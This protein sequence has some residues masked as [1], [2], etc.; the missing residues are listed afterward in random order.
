MNERSGSEDPTVGVSSSDSVPHE[1]HAPEAQPPLPGEPIGV[2]LAAHRKLRGIS[3][4]ELCEQTRI[5]LRSLERL[6]GGAF[7]GQADGFVRG[8]VRTV[9]ISLG[10]DPEE[11]V[12]RMQSEPDG[13]MGRRPMA[14]LSL[15]R[16]FLTAVLVFGSAGLIALG[17]SVLDRVPDG[18]RGSAEP[19]SIRRDPVR[20]LA[21]A[22]GI[23]GLSE[24][25]TT[26]AAAH[27]RPE[28]PV[29]D[30][31]TALSHQAVPARPRSHVR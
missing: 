3:L 26:L 22:Q 24:R 30:D 10:L 14:R 27:R 21:E 23:E 25:M 7:D 12:A 5:P 2:Y 29:A 11:T 9:A 28:L 16:V 8:F 13:Q 20:A 18:A 15:R 4:A 31:T 1:S 6:E 19:V 17:S